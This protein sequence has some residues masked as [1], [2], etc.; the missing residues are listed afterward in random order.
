[1]KVNADLEK[2]V[3]A[4]VAEETG[5]RLDRLSLDTRIVE[6][7]GCDGHDAVELFEAFARYFEVN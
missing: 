5:M 4:L 7:I 3:K 1:V 2:R 6:D